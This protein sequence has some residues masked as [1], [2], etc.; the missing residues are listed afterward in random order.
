[1]TRVSYR[2]DGFCRR[3]ER[4]RR[5]TPCPGNNCIFLPL[6]ALGE[7]AGTGSGLKLPSMQLDPVPPADDQRDRKLPRETTAGKSY[8]IPALEIV[9]FDVLLNQF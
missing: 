2:L 4:F 7:E 1:M 9:G 3:A 5:E 8:L 6:A